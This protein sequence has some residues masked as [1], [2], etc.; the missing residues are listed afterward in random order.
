MLHQSTANSHLSMAWSDVI[1]RRYRDDLYVMKQ[2]A[3]ALKVAKYPCTAGQEGLAIEHINKI[4]IR[5]RQGG[6]WWRWHGHQ[7]DLKKIWQTAGIPVWL[8]DDY[9]LL[10][11]GA[12]LVAIPDI[13]VADAWCVKTGNAVCF[14]LNSA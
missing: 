5:Y 10:Y 6:E 14:T 3:A 1:V 8:R 12:E 2:K 11:I 13:G 9:P 4:E 7:R